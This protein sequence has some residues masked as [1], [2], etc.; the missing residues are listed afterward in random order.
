V[1]R[2]PSRPGL[3]GIDGQ[4][5]S[6][7]PIA[8]GLASSS[9]LVIA[10]AL[11]L[12]KANDATVAP[13]QLAE[14]MARAERLV[15]VQGGGMDQAACLCGA[16]GHAVRID[17]DPLRIS[18]VT[19][20]D[21][22]QWI[23]A[24]SLDRAEKS[25]GARDAYNSRTSA[26]R[27]ALAQMTLACGLGGPAERPS[28]RALMAAFS[29]PELLDRSQSVLGDELFRRFRHVVTEGHRVPLA[30][31]AMAAG[32]LAAFGRL[33]IQSHASLRDDYEVST[34]ALDRIV[35]IAIKAGAAGARLTGAGFGGCAVI[36]CDRQ[37][38]PAVREALA[39]H[40]YAKHLPCQQ[41]RPPLEDVL[42]AARPT[43]GASV[44]AL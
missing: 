26:C 44:M 28:Y 42:L 43:Q 15:G 16:D 3:R 32:D 1:S 37:S 17:F 5:N 13:V 18:T 27:E 10:S 21:G 23:V 9:A 19:V 7:L 14:I 31:Q 11:A 33:M 34:P 39:R 22:W 40:F 20:P 8:S 29:L 30:Q 6:D 38:A 12:L 41:P 2:G 4:V 24:S 35:S 36:L 25:R